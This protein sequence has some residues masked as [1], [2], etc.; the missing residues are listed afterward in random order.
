M[1]SYNIM[2]VTRITQ[3]MLVW[4]LFYPNYAQNLILCHVTLIFPRPANYA[5]NYA[6]LNRQSLLRAPAFKEAG[7]ALVKVLHLLA[8]MYCKSVL[9]NTGESTSSTEYTRVTLAK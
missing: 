6:N 2:Q 4:A 7:N 9:I 8:Y 5:E 3:I 1:L